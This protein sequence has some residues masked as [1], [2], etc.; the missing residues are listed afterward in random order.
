MKVLVLGAGA[1]GCY[2]GG[3]LSLAGFELAFAVRP[4]ARDGVAA[5]SVRLCG[6]RGD[7]HTAGVGA[8]VRTEEAP[9]VVYRDELRIRCL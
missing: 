3:L 4:A 2:V 8:I 7:F 6:L 9:G 1:V 5:R